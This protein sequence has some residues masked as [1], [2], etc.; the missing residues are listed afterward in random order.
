MEMLEVIFTRPDKQV[1]ALV[2]GSGV[3]STIQLITPE[4][5]PTKERVFNDIYRARSAL[6]CAAK[7][8]D[9]LKA[10]PLPRM[11]H[12]SR[13]PVVQPKP[14]PLLVIHEGELSTGLATR[15]DGHSIIIINGRR[16]RPDAAAWWSYL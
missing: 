5:I 13:F 12:W 4:G 10:S 9:T 1:Y 11:S 15:A 14:K 16:L 3:E 2:K 8:D 6:I 7:R